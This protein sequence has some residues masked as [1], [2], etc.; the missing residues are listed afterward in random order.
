MV[1]LCTP[2]LSELHPKIWMRP[3]GARFSELSSCCFF[4]LNAPSY[5]A[6][7]RSSRALFALVLGKRTTTMM[8]AKV[9]KDASDRAVQ[10]EDYG[11][12]PCR[13]V[14]LLQSSLNLFASSKHLKKP[15]HCFCAAVERKLVTLFDKNC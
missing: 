9:A 1:H 10:T 4:C 5:N 13:F 15:L 8:M 3:R 14:F 2:V 12:P 6:G 11:L 7:V